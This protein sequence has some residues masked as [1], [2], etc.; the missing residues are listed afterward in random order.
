V[1]D[2]TFNATFQLPI[3]LWRPN[4]EDQP[5]HALYLKGISLPPEAP[6]ILWLALP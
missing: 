2:L 6:D 3:F 4:P 5:D 1:N